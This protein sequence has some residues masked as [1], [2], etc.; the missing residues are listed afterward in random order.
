MLRSFSCFLHELCSETCAL[1]KTGRYVIR[2]L[3]L[4]ITCGGNAPLFPL[5]NLEIMCCFLLLLLCPKYGKGECERTS[6]LNLNH[7]VFAVFAG[8]AVNVSNFIGALK[9]LAAFNV[10]SVFV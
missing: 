7:S 3:M 2:K 8:I 6:N 4:L 5:F 10:P 1:D 9:R